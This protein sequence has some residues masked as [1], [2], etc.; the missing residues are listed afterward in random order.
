VP[1]YENDIHFLSYLTASLC[2]NNRK[3]FFS[4]KPRKYTKITVL[5]EPNCAKEESVAIGKLK[6]CD[7]FVID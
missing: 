4:E 6:N 2:K 5:K 7:I 3:K 1:H